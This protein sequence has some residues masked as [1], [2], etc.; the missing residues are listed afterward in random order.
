VGSEVDGE[1]CGTCV[2]HIKFVGDG[3]PFKTAIRNHPPI[4]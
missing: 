4:A 2:I 3:I 1:G